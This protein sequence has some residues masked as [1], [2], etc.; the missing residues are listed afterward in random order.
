[1]SGLVADAALV[2]QAALV[3]AVLESVRRRSVPAIVNGVGSLGVA[4]SPAAVGAA[5]GVTVVPELPLWAA[6][7]GLVHT[8]GMLGFYDSVWWWDHLAHTVSAALLTALVYA[9][10]LVGST[11]AG[12]W[13]LGP[14]GVVT[15]TVGLVV[16]LAVVWELVEEV[17]RLVSE[18]YDVGPVLVVYGPLDAVFD[19]AFNLV[20][21]GLVILLDLRLFVPVF[22]SH[23]T[24]TLRLLLVVGGVAVASL[25][26]LALGLA[27]SEADWP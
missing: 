27:R 18:R 10:V 26:G 7:A 24:A 12:A 6:V 22:E 3:L 4:L 23:P 21:A 11:A 20:G 25:A 19:L 2:L 14:T 16:L 1:M 8:V 5:T 9:A 13:P 15:A 17:A